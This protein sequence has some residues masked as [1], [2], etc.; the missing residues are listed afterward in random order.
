MVISDG[1]N[2]QIDTRSAS[3]VPVLAVR[4]SASN[5]GTGNGKTEHFPTPKNVALAELTRNQVGLH[6]PRMKLAL[7]AGFAALLLLTASCTTTR[8]GVVVSKGVNKMSGN[9]GAGPVYWVELRSTDAEGKT[10]T[11]RVVVFE[12]DWRQIQQGQTYPA[13]GHADQSV[14]K[15]E[16]SPTEKKK[17]PKTASLQPGVQATPTPKTKALKVQKPKATESTPPKPEEPATPRSPGA[18]W[19][20]LFGDEKNKAKAAP[21]PTPASTPKK[22]AVVKKVPHVESEDPTLALPKDPA[23]KPPKEPAPK[24]KPVKQPVQ[25][26]EGQK[27]A[28]FRDVQ[29]RAMEDRS[30]HAWKQKAHD[31]T[32]SEEQQAAMREYRKALYEKMRKIDPALKDD[33]D[34]AEGG[35]PSP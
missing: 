12:K 22:H 29:A 27:E 9:T 28:H 4:I 21:S 8:E 18:L 30:V 26:T 7:S 1:V 15:P 25:M 35:T 33:V 32:T 20:S 24:S 34:K 13:G 5:A 14:K 3:P 11:R 31:A 6:Y 16:A 17:G 23:P 2:E 10:A 19:Q